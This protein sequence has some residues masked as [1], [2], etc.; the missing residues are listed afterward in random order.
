MIFAYRLRASKDHIRR[1]LVEYMDVAHVHECVY[2]CEG[3]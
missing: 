2:V 3:G 1:F